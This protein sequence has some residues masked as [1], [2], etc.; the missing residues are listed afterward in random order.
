MTGHINRRGWIVRDSVQSGDHCFCVDFFEDPKGGFGF[1]Q[2]RSD[3]E[4]GGW[5]PISGYAAVRYA[6][7]DEAVERAF[8]LVPWLAAAAYSP[9][10]GN[11]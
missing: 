1:E 11:P 7:L 8:A 3:P 5:T 10:N 9:R 4:D 6:T 2:F